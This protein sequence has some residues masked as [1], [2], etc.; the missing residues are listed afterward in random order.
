MGLG[1]LITAAASV[2]DA[3]DSA[4]IPNCVIGGLAVAR[5]GEA[6]L[7]KDVD[8]AAFSGIGGESRVIDCVLPVCHARVDD[9]R[10]FAM[11]HRTLVVERGQIPIDV[12][13]AALPFE[14][15]MMT[16]RALPGTRPASR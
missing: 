15:R 3:L 16:G 9:P 4:G 6:R 5:W 1:E 7:T 2:Q 13:L 8:F 11:R 10:A 14:K 12:S